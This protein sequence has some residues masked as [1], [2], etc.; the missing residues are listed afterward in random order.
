MQSFKFLFPSPTTIFVNKVL[1]DMTWQ[2]K[3]EKR[4]HH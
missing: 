3:S 2:V 1:N 4:L